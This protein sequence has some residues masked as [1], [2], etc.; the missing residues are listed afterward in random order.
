MTLDG[1]RVFLLF[2]FPLVLSSPAAAQ[3][4]RTG[5]LS[6]SFDDMTV[7]SGA[8]R[9]HASQWAQ[10]YKLDLD[11]PLLNPVL[12]NMHD[13]F[14]YG[15]GASISQAANTGIPHQQLTS[16]TANADFFNLRTRRYVRLSPNFSRNYIRQTGDANG[17]AYANKV[18]NTSWGLSSGLSLPRL[19]ALG[20]SR[21]INA[22]SNPSELSPVNQRSTTENRSVSYALG[23]IVM[24]A[25]QQT[26]RIE[27][28]LGLVARQDNDFRQASL[29]ANYYEPK[30]IKLES[31][32][33]RTDVTQNANDGNLT[34]KQGTSNLGLFTRKFQWGRWESAL[35]YGT[36]AS[37]DFIHEVNNFSQNAGL[38][39]T[40]AIRRGTLGNSA[41][42]SH[43]PSDPSESIS[44]GLSVNQ[45]FWNGLLGTNLGASGGW[46][47]GA[48]STTLSDGL[49][50]RL[51]LRAAR[52]PLIFFAEARTSGSEALRGSG[53]GRTSRYGLGADS[54]NDGATLTARLDRTHLRNYAA[55]S[56]SVSDQ[57]VLE[58]SARPTP[59]LYS[60]A[61]YNL[62]VLRRPG[63]PG[64]VS[65]NLHGSLDY[66]PWRA[67]TLSASATYAA[68]G[69]TAAASAGYHLGKTALKISYDYRESKTP[70]GFS[71]LSISLS[72][73]L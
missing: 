40:R 38:S 25:S 71:H 20:Y 45:L 6:W 61:G 18:A 51:D 32:F 24:N 8:G 22:M 29:E 53:G 73:M 60:S 39:S 63:A 49:N 7:N 34:Q 64:A 46:N 31:F 2:L 37:R 44:D 69:Y 62:G 4:R 27:D 72:R 16:L 43:S 48:V 58:I 67:V 14:S 19:P 30:W 5:L 47:H 50:G 15:E 11:G 9:V 1:A 52:R 3:Y 56:M 66:N 57:L 65:H 23:H 70:A 55:G 68:A 41:S 36:A 10:S 12:G 13:A 17:G 35:N 28:R 33:F 26:D 21:Q 59:K 42:F 54:R